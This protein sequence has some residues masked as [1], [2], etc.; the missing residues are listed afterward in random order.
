MRCQ[1]ERERTYFD[2]KFDRATQVSN[3][4]HR[5]KYSANY[6][7]SS[8]LHIPLSYLIPTVIIKKYVQEKREL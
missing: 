2:L 7:W 1:A 4:A 6:S 8:V 3:G 5:S